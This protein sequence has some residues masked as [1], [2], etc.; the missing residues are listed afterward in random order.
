MSIQAEKF[1][2]FDVESFI[3]FQV[4]VFGWDNNEQVTGV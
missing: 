3:P 4:E 2:S 1:T